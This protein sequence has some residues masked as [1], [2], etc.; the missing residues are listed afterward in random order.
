M[1][2]KND[3]YGS[4]SEWL[5]CADHRCLAAQQPGCNQEQQHDTA[6]NH[7]YIQRRTSGCALICQGIDHTIRDVVGRKYLDNGR[8]RIVSKELSECPHEEDGNDIDYG[9]HPCS[10]PGTTCCL[11]EAAQEQAKRHAE[12]RTQQG[13]KQ[14]QGNLA[15]ETAVDDQHQGSQ[16]E[17]IDQA[18]QQFAC[19]HITVGRVLM[20]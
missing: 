11:E 3:A 8:E 7:T 9:E 2:Q 4:S 20:S 12:E 19:Y 14:H 1:N 18:H 15:G 13:E 6:E 5:N 17:L 16:Q 10:R